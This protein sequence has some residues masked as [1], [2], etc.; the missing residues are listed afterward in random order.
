MY[1]FIVIYAILIIIMTA[2]LIVVWRSRCMLEKHTGMRTEVQREQA[3]LSVKTARLLW[4]FIVLEEADNIIH[5]VS[6]SRD[7]R[8]FWLGFFLAS[9]LFIIG[10]MGVNLAFIVRQAREKRRQKLQSRD[11]M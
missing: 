5:V 10:F 4:L 1:T 9:L 7:F 3:V 8:M 11:I 2:I 6:V